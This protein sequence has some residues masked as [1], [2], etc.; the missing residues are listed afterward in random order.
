MEF[1]VSPQLPTSGQLLGVLVD[2]MGFQD[3]MLRDKTAKRFF[4][5]RRDEQVKELSREETLAAIVE[6]L[7][8]LDFEATPQPKDE[9]PFHS[10][11]SSILDEHTV[12]WDRLRAFLLPRMMR[13]YPS[14]LATLWKAYLRAGEYRFGPEASCTPP[15][16]RRVGDSAGLPRRGRMS[17]GGE[18][19]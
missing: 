4:S 15:L 13:V 7:A 9:M 14:S 2:T 3:A 6:T 12:N 10:V 19:T 5:G 17:P 16:Y 1:E 11:L 18:N 8:V